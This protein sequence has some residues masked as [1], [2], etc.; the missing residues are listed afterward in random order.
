[1]WHLPVA[2]NI[3]LR[4]LVI[5]RQFTVICHTAISQL[6]HLSKPSVTL[7]SIAGYAPSVCLCLSRSISPNC[8]SNLR[9]IFIHVISGRGSHWL[10]P[11]LMASSYD[12]YFRFVDGVVFAHNGRE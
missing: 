12:M 11:P 8:S 6:V 4:R 2:I 5:F 10:S 7:V 3:V 9:H 1:M